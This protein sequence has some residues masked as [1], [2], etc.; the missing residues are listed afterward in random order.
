MNKHTPGPWKFDQTRDQIFSA[1]PDH[2]HSLICKIATGEDIREELA[3]G[4]LIAAAPDLLAVT[5]QVL[6]DLNGRNATLRAIVR[7]YAQSPLCSCINELVKLAA[8]AAEKAN[9]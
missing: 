9:L 1:H 4:A 8:E 7:A 6:G 3:N 5:K 2:T